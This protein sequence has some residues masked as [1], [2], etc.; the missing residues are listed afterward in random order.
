MD[1]RIEAFLDI[2]EGYRRRAGDRRADDWSSATGTCCSKARTR[3]ASTGAPV[4]RLGLRDP[5]VKLIWPSMGALGT[6][7]ISQIARDYGIDSVALAP[8]DVRNRG[9]RPRGGQR[10]GVHPARCSCSAPSCSTSPRNEID[11]NRVYLLFMPLTTGPCRT[12]QYAV[13]YQN[14][15]QELGYKNVVVLSLNSDNSY[16]ELGGEFNKRAWWSIVLS[17]YMVDVQMALRALAV[18]RA[19]AQAVYDAVCKEMVEAAGNGIAA[20]EQGLPRWARKLGGIRLKRRMLPGAARA[21]RRR[22]SSC[23][24]T[25][26]RFETLH[27][28]PGR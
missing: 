13:F 2:I 3:H 22:R 20:L 14:L 6:R 7:L 16:A 1:T 25:T 23:G 11:P 12:G 18:D 24:A 4:E 27:R 5:R 8:A 17:D 26:S 28:A 9:A 19:E 15:F 21:R 10:Q